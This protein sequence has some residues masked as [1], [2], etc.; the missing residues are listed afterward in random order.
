MEKKHVWNH[1]PAMHLVKMSWVHGVLLCHIEVRGQLIALAKT[2]LESSTQ[3]L[4]SIRTNSMQ[5]KMKQ[6]LV[7]IN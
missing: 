2:P 4:K 7:K 5:Q 6:K 3:Q 1:P